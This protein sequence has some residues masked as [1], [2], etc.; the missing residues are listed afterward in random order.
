[1]QM[2]PNFTIFQ[3]L[4]SRKLPTGFQLV[5]DLSSQI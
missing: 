5:T 1:M 2:S 3:D 4:L